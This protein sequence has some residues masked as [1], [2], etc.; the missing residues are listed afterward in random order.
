[1]TTDIFVSLQH[2]FNNSNTFTPLILYNT[3]PK[4]D[5]KRDVPPI[6]YIVVYTKYNFYSFFV[7]FFSFFI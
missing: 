5:E 1:M 7:F 3:V 6:L 2:G 4:K